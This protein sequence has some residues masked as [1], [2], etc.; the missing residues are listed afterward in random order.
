MFILEF[1]DWKTLKRKVIAAVTMGEQLIFES[2]RSIVSPPLQIQVFFCYS[3]Q[4][5]FHIFPP[6]FVM[7]Y[8]FISGFTHVQVR[9]TADSGLPDIATIF[10]VYLKDVTSCLGFNLKPDSEFPHPSHH[11]RL[12]VGNAS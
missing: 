11:S 6:Y 1:A 3:I 12:Q 4:S 7:P 8:N 2:R 10:Q 9:L 5:F